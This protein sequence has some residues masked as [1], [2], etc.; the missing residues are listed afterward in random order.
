MIQY[1]QKIQKGHVKMSFVKVE[2]LIKNY[3]SFCAVDCLCF[4]VGKGEIFGLLGPNGAGKST[5]INVIT[6]IDEPDSGKVSV[7]GYDTVKQRSEV[8]KI[9]GIVPQDIALYPYLSAVENVKFFASLY[10]LKGKQLEESAMRALE[11]TGLSEYAKLK[12]KKMSGGMKRRLNI[13]CGIAHHPELIVMDEPTVGVDAQSREHI[14]NSIKLLRDK[15]ATIIY[16]SHYMHEVEEI[17][18]R[19]AIIDH[20]RMAAQGSEQELVSMITDSKTILITTR[21]PSGFDVDEFVKKLKL[22]PDVNSVSCQDNTVKLDVRLAGTDF[23]YI[24]DEVRKYGLPLR[25][26]QST[27]PDL[28]AVFLALTGHELR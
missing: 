6:T 22:L 8:R 12:A 3:G 21:F 14:L 27:V 16:T 18:D 4:E 5:T 23:A 10:G 1:E 28:D 9:I 24:I 26:V 13:A 19:M 2:K 25:A 7:N 11:F 17:C 20:G 15:G